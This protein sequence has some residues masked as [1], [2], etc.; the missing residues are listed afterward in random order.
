MRAGTAVKTE[1]GD[2]KIISVEREMVGVFAGLDVWTI[3]D[4]RGEIA[5][6]Y[7]QVGKEPSMIVLTDIARGVS[8]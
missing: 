8:L 1:Y 3:T 6:I 7:C 5:H 4:P 2:V